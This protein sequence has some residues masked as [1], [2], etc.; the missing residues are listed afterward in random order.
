MEKKLSIF[1][2][3][4][5][6]SMATEHTVTPICKEGALLSFLHHILSAFIYLSPFLFKEYKVQL[7][8]LFLIL[9][10]KKGVGRCIMKY[11][12]NPKN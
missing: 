3:I 12:I 1:F 2:A 5:F 4:V 10:G 8:L 6:L 7:G 11:V 9:I